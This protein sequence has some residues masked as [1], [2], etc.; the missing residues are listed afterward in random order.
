[1]KAILAMIGVLVLIG[2]NQALSKPNQE[3]Q[4]VNPQ[5]EVQMKNLFWSLRK[6]SSLIGKSYLEAKTGRRPKSTMMNKISGL[7][8]PRPDESFYPFEVKDDMKELKEEWNDFKYYKG[9]GPVTSRPFTYLD[10]R[11]IG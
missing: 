4:V 11:I 2:L 9:L 5:T 7:N 1:M 10:L 3:S 6:A 8:L